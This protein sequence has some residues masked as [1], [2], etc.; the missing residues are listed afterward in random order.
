MGFLYGYSPSMSP[1][2]IRPPVIRSSR[3]AASFSRCSIPASGSYPTKRLC[4]AMIIL[5]HIS[6][7]LSTALLFGR[8]FSQHLPGIPRHPAPLPGVGTE[9]R[10]S[11]G[12]HYGIRTRGC[13][14]QESAG[15][16]VRHGRGGRYHLTLEVP[17]LAGSTQQLCGILDTVREKCLRLVIIGSLTPDCREAKA[18]PMREAFLQMAGVFSQ[19]ELA[20]IRTRVRSGM[21]SAKGNQIGRPPK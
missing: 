13:Q 6:F 20:M 18:D 19:L 8:V 21:A 3:D 12:N 2:G 15:G 4:P 5:Y 17:R 16:H 1:R 7:I 9:G 14:G 10:R 11:R